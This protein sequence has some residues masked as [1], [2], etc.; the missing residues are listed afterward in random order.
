MSQYT[1]AAQLVSKVRHL[2]LYLF[3]LTYMYMV[4]TYRYVSVALP[5]S[6]KTSWD[7][8]TTRG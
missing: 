2:L 8:T 1:A 5:V 7:F 4:Y 6:S 3:A